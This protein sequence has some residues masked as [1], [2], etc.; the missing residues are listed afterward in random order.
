MFA[1]PVP[2]TN[3]S[4]EDPVLAVGDISL[5]P[6][7]GWIE[8]IINPPA[9]GTGL[10]GTVIVNPLP[11]NSASDGNNYLNSQ[12]LLSAPGITTVEVSQ[13][14]GTV[15][16]DT[17]YD[18]TA[19]LTT[20][21]GFGC[22]DVTRTLIF[23]VD[24]LD[25]GVGVFFADGTGNTGFFSPSSGPLIG[26]PIEVVLQNT[27]TTFACLP[28]EQAT[29]NVAFDNVIL[30]AQD[31]N[32][33]DDDGDGVPN[34]Q[35]ICPGFDDNVDSDGDGTP[36]G[37]DTLDNNDCG[38]GTI[39]DNNLGQC[40]GTN[41]G[42]Q[43]GDKTESDGFFCVPKLDEI[44][45]QGTTPNFNSVMCVVT[46]LGNMIGGELLDINTVSLLVGAIGVNPVI[47]G[48]VGITLAG[49]VGQ[50]V[51]FVHKRKKNNS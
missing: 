49:I 42:F 19:D 6:H 7:V 9:P 40:I 29:S 30:T 2:I 17:H 46:N 36:D 37:C 26:K 20:L 1:V 22:A 50:A 16:P 48:L 38:I 15:Q 3:H 13:N 33:L 12:I 24:G 43:C 14:V 11:P 18:L 39:A 21:S 51:W 27:A 23:R 32:L 41:Q 25:V 47:T 31:L 28:G 44:C 34:G 5:A 45:G 35:D 4:F 8:N 10:A